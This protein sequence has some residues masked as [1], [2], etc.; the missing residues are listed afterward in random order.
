MLILFIIIFFQT[1]GIPQPDRLFRFAITIPTILVM[2][3]GLLRLMTYFIYLMDTASE[4]YG[5]SLLAYWPTIVYSLLPVVAGAIYEPFAVILNNFEC[6]R[7]NVRI[8]L[9]FITINFIT[10]ILFIFC[11]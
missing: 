7:T 8:L 9:I 10:I 2:I 5:S 6:H 11:Y 1:I 3:I 4:T